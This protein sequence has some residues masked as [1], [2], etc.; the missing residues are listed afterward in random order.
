[1]VPKVVNPK[2]PVDPP[3]EPETEPEPVRPKTVQKPQANA[4]LP[5][6]GDI[7]VKPGVVA[8]TPDQVQLQFAD[9]YYA[10]KMWREAAPEYERYLE[11]Y[12]KAV[13]LDRQAGYYR[14][15]EC[16][17]LTGAVNNAKA[18]YDAVLTNFN[19]GEFVGYAAYRLADIYYTEKD[20]RSALPIYRRASV[21]LT[22]PT[23]INASKF[24]IARCLEANGQKT[25]ARV[26][27]EDLARVTE[28]NPYRDA[29]R[30]SVGR[31]HDEAKQ[32]QDAL[33]WLQPLAAETTNAS[34]KAD[35]LARSGMLLLDL[36]KHDQA[37]ETMQAAIDLPDAA[38][39]KNDLQLGVYRAL[40]AKKDYAGV[41]ARYEKGIPEGITVEAKLNILVVVGSAYRDLQ[42][43]DAAMAIFDQ[44]V[45]EFP[46][47]P[48]S[49]D[50][51]YA[52][53]VMLYDTSD[54]R[55]LD[56]INKFLTDNPTAPQVERVSL[57]KAEVLFKKSAW[58][59]AGAIY[60]VIIEKSRGLSGDLK[61]E[62]TF[63]LG[64]CWMQLRQFEKAIA[65]FTLFRRDHPLHAKMPIAL[66]QQGAAHMQ[67]KQYTA[68]VKVLEELVSKHPKAREREFGLENLG[69]AYGQLLDQPRMGETFEV[70]LRDFP[71][72]PAKAKAH[73]WIG[74]SAAA[75]KDYKKVVPQMRA[76]LE[77]A[78]TSK[79]TKDQYFEKASRALITSLFNTED[80]E[81]VEK[82]TERYRADGGAAEIESDIIRWLALKHHENGDHEKTI[83]DL[84]TLKARKEAAPEDVLMLARAH[85]K[86][87]KYKEAVDSFD[88]YLTIIKDPL[89]RSQALLEKIDAQ[90]AQKDWVGADATVKE[91]LSIATE[92]KINGEFRFRAAEAEEGRGNLEKARQIFE[93]IPVTLDD[94]DVCPR[95]LE[96]AARIQRQLGND[97][98]AKRLE[99]Q[100]RSKYPEYFQKKRT[101]AETKTP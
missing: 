7:V 85:T 12:P 26:Q 51:A 33:K 91:G 35:A 72:T 17:R 87:G 86:L 50:A 27:Y 13:P 45:K 9:G 20:Y 101:P 64:W 44:V 53:I 40:Y 97:V 60:E 36:N 1:V 58:A 5:E 76:V 71:E 41:V 37:V 24:F 31:L 84:E 99:N 55:L 49:R 30:L 81:G 39:W 14:L 43:R 75:R 16:Y 74:Y 63:K 34:I 22:Q 11:K 62:A 57:M 82:E 80:V 38:A 32:R 59:D 21:R 10:K 56:E 89:R 2:K 25:E 3:M 52:R 61:G 6:P 90:L 4:D 18:N 48:Q 73:Y 95:A 78:R 93:S 23:L 96:R 79:E 28:G 68:A 98:E 66:A 54:E 83:A 69:I 92:G 70:L 8:T 15:A 77:V 29:S 65:V 46:G 19:G 100:L 47:T 88:A 67:L 42:K 94:D